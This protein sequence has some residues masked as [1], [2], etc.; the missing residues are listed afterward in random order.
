[1]IPGDGRFWALL[2]P[3]EQQI[4]SQMQNWIVLSWYIV[5]NKG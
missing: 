1:M 2:S 5:V 3:Q 4:Y